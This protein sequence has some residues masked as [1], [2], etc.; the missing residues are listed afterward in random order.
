M[1]EP[2]GSADPRSKV[3]TKEFIQSLERPDFKFDAVEAAFF[4]QWDAFA[5]KDVWLTFDDGPHGSHTDQILSA[6]AKV[7][8]KATFFMVGAQAV[9]NPAVAKRV[10]DAGHRVGNHTWSHQKLTGLDEAGIRVEISKAEQVLKPYLG[11]AKLLRQPYG[12]TNA[13]VD[14]VVK[15]MGYRSVLW[16]VDTEDWSAARQPTAWMDFGLEQV[17]TKAHCVILMH[18]IQKTTAENLPVFLKSLQQIAG[19]FPIQPPSSL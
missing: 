19:A 4:P 14:K 3:V 17:R 8:A 2:I 11:D 6:L 1:S 7:G 18:D 13:L 10:F 15:D 12:A 9:A 16:T 5:G